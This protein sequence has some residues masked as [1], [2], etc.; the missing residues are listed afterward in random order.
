MYYLLIIAVGVLFIGGYRALSRSSWSLPLSVVRIC[1][2]V[3]FITLAAGIG[4]LYL[5][6]FRKTKFSVDVLNQLILLLPLITAFLLASL[7][8]EKLS[9]NERLYFRTFQIIPLGGLLVLMIPFLGLSLLF[10]LLF[11][12]GTVYYEDENI[13][14]E[15]T[16]Y[17]VLAM[18]YPPDVYQ[19]RGPFVTRLTTKIYCP[20]SVDEVK[21]Q[22]T[23][24]SYRIYYLTE[25]H[26]Q[27]TCLKDIQL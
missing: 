11:P 9:R 19:K 15:Q 5:V 24:K 1:R 2:Y 8:K 23:G 3:H 16:F 12:G 20:G 27:E 25:D 7:E 26:P 14:I 18:R 13:R 4:W 17:G 22:R 10:Y 6:L 21:V